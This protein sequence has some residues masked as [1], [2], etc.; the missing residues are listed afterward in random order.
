[1]ASGTIL[2]VEDNTIQREGLAV[3]LRQQGFSVVLAS[4]G[5]EAAAVLEHVRPNVVLLDMLIPESHGDGWWF[6]DQRQHNPTLAAVPVLIT[7]ALPVA[8]KEWASSLGAA[9]L[10]RK[11]FDV[12]PLVVAI[13]RCIEESQTLKS[14]SVADDDS[15]YRR[16]GPVLDGRWPTPT[17]CETGP[18]HGRDRPNNRAPLRLS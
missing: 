15:P 1:M 16:R 7:T 14:R 17:D 12:E 4:D 13:R 3:V 2:I 11:P 8:S 9:G 18:E 10:V 6:L 5:Q